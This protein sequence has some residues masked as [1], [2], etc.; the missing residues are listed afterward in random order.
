MAG[1]L[2]DLWSRRL[3][4]PVLLGRYVLLKTAILIAFLIILAGWDSHSVVYEGF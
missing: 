4:D 2:L 3:D 1:K